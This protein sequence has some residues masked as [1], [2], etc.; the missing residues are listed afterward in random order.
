MAKMAWRLLESKPLVNTPERG[1]VTH[2]R[3]ADKTSTKGKLGVYLND[4]YSK[5]LFIIQVRI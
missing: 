2:A 5:I 4:K 1:A 3:G